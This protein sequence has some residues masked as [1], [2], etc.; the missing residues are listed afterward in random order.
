MTTTAGTPHAHSRRSFL[1][2]VGAVGGASA[3]YGSMEA[4]G[5]FASPAEAATSDFAPPRAADLPDSA[6]S[7]GTKVVILGAGT[8]GLAAA[9]ELGKAGYDCTV[10]EARDRPGGR[11]K[12]IRRGDRLTDTDGVSQTCGFDDGLYFNAGPARIPNHHV[13]LDYCRELGV[14]I[15]ALVN[16]NAESLYYHENTSGT[17]YG[18]LAG[19]SVTHRQA[20][21]DV[22]GYIS[23][24]LAQATNQGALDETLST[25]DAE[26]VIELANSLGGLTGGRYVGNSRRGY[27]DAPGAGHDAGVAG[28][29]PSMSAILQ[30]RFGTRFAFEFG[31]D[32]AMMMWQPVGGM[33]RISSALAAAIGGKRRITYNAPVTQ[34]QN[35]PD[36]VRV[37][38]RLNGR[39]RTVEA[40]YC[41][42]TIPP[43][44]LKGI[45]ANFTQA[46]KDAL[47][48]P[49]GANTGKIGL[50]YGRRWWEEDDKIFGGITATNMDISGIWY[51]S[52]GF[53]GRKGVVV[54]YYSGSYTDLPVAGRSERAVEQGV[55]IHGD[56]YRDELETSI[57]IAWP[58]EPYS[59]G[60][61]VN[62]PGGRGPAYDQLLRPDGRTYF[63]GDHLSYLIAWQAGAFESARQVVTALHERV[64]A[65]AA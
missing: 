55:K 46:T 62:W 57:S 52:S 35:L 8:A 4:L 59:L 12:T 44:V 42:A 48:V 58:K 47:T 22:Y 23:E 2:R 9:Y 27:V 3:L 21:A 13:T 7:R 25:D 16:A 19:T 63:A 65:T 14:A 64:A 24:L 15:E 43:M 28:T 39:T 29:P 41:I 60:G 51:P 53:L 10:L 17:D 54:G 26:R 6:R 45:P 56:R 18:E 31:F 33:D 61:W 30:S 49:T 37:S 36:G 11:A 32:Q 50:Q 40:D 5:L 34:I 20:K 1:T 38:Y